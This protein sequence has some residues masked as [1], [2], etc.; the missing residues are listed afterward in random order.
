LNRRVVPPKQEIPRNSLLEVAAV[1][2]PS[3]DV[4]RKR[5]ASKGGKYDHSS[6]HML[7][8]NAM[9]HLTQRDAV[10]PD[11]RTAQLGYVFPQDSLRTF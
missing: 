7:E 8:G 10:K 11:V 5:K 1:A 2:Q 3:A 4:Q 9:P 6:M